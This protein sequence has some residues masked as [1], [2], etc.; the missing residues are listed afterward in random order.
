MSLIVAIGDRAKFT[1][2]AEIS[3][4]IDYNGVSFFGCWRNTGVQKIEM[5]NVNSSAPREVLSN[6][7]SIFNSL[8][9]LCKLISKTFGLY[10][11]FHSFYESQLRSSGYMVVNRRQVGNDRRD[12]WLFFHCSAESWETRWRSRRIRF[13]DLFPI[14]VMHYNTAI[15]NNI[16]HLRKWNFV[17][18]SRDDYESLS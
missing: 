12:Y 7:K 6:Q 11:Y 10:L 2:R 14:V 8:E 13:S 5:M 15:R 18:S 9:N 17:V 1:T 3:I 4:E 16:N